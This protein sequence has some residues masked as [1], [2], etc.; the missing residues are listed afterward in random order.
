LSAAIRGAFAEAEVQ[1]EQHYLLIHRVND[2][3]F[4]GNRETKIKL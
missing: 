4:N 3:S 1:Q 2:G